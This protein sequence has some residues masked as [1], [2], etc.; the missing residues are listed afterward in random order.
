MSDDAQ[1]FL[2]CPECHLGF[3]WMY[4][5][6]APESEIPNYCPRCGKEW[7]RLR[8]LVAFFLVHDEGDPRRMVVVEYLRKRGILCI[9]HQDADAGFE[10]LKSGFPETV[11]ESWDGGLNILVL[12]GEEG[13]LSFVDGPT[14]KDLAMYLPEQLL[15]L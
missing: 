12:W 4:M 11:K 3:P 13:K 8:V 10:F 14:P 6:D 7:K 1:E 2:R 9:V 15:I 5:G